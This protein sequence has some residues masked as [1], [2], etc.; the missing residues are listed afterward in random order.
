M[1]IGPSGIG[2]TTLLSLLIQKYVPFQGKILINNEIGLDNISY[3]FWQKKC[4]YL[5]SNSIIHN[6]TV[7]ENILSFNIIKEKLINFQ[8]LGFNDLLGSL[9]LTTFYY[10]Q[11]YG[12]NLSQ[13][14]KQIIIFLSLFFYDWKVILLDEILSN[15]N[16]DLKI[17]LITLLLNHYKKIIIIYAGHDLTLVK[18][19]GDCQKSGI[20]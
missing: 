17:K 12:A 8:K 4:I 14:Q 3:E 19:L 18:L 6:G 20:N 15:I 13:G 2:K 11:E 1:I 10:C 16:N 9:G 5:H 7:L